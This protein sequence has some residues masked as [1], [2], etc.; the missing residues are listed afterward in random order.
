M[1]LSRVSRVGLLSVMWFS[2]V[3][4]L[5]KGCAV[6][7]LNPAACGAKGIK[8]NYGIPVVLAGVGAVNSLMAQN[9]CV[10]H[11]VLLWFDTK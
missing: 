1:T 6:P 11:G 2:L 4:L 8:Q 10:C 9:D 3:E 5:D 7:H